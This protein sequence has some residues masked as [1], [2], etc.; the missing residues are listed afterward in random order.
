[1][2][3]RTRPR[4]LLASPGDHLKLLADEQPLNE[5]S[6]FTLD[7][8]TAR[9]LWAEHG[10]AITLRWARIH[11]GTRPSW[12]WRL[13]APEPRQLLSGVGRPLWQRFPNIEPTYEY[14]LP[15]WCGDPDV[16]PEFESQFD[17]LKRLGL[18]VRREGR[19]PNGEPH[20]HPFVR[21]DDGKEPPKATA[22]VDR[23]RAPPLSLR[24]RKGRAGG[25]GAFSDF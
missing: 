3:R 6:Q 5:F 10:D 25:G 4:H 20:P 12:W 16:P 15:E 8:E 22:N 24:R 13:Q 9:A 14:G 19:P 17:Y 18:L 2:N 11:P 23:P 7:E 21:R 1:M